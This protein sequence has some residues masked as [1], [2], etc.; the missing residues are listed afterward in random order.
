MLFDLLRREEEGDGELTIP[1]TSAFD[2]LRLT[3][4]GEGAASPPS[5]FVLL[6]FLRRDEE[7]D[8]ETADAAIFVEEA[9]DEHWDV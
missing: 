8:G 2:L 6:A 3:E 5:S 9:L 4:E 7:G 1:S